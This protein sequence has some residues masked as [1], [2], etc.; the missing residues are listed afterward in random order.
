MMH[1]T[2]QLKLSGLI[3]PGRRLTRKMPYTLPTQ[4]L[5]SERQM[6]NQ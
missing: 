1:G 5:T 6:P 4:Y 2:P 3:N